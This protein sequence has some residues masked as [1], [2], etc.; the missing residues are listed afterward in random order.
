MFESEPVKCHYSWKQRRC[1][2]AS[3][4]VSVIHIYMTTV[5]IISGQADMLCRILILNSFISGIDNNKDRGHCYINWLVEKKK[6]HFEQVVDEI[7]IFPHSEAQDL[8]PPISKQELISWGILKCTGTYLWAIQLKD[9]YI[10]ACSRLCITVNNLNRCSHF[11]SLCCLCMC[12]CHWR[13]SCVIL[14]LLMCDLR[15]PHVWS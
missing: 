4:I 6:R 7:E 5:F 13:S 3:I 11:C 2:A 14:G 9:R 1:E 10:L 15:A 12:D 8:S